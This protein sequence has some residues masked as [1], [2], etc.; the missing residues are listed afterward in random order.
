MATN[1]DLARRLLGAARED[2][3]MANSL[4][5]VKGVTDAGIGLHAQQAVEKAIKAVLSAEKTEFPFT[6]DLERL[7]Q[8]AKKSGIE[9]PTTLDGIKALTP[10]ALDE[11][12]GAETPIGL[13]RDQALKWAAAAIA[14]AGTLIE[15]TDPPQTPPAAPS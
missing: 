2:E 3:L 12:Y 7:K 5:P 10:F 14:W 9:L 13:D 11:R 1:G 4:L 6:H 15:E 8:F